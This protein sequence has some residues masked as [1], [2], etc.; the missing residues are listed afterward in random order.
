MEAQRLA[1]EAGDED[2]LLRT[3]LAALWWA[4]TRHYVTG[5]EDAMTWE[6]AEEGYRVTLAAAAHFEQRQDWGSFSETLDLHPEFAA[7]LGRAD[8]V[9]ESFRRR[10]GAPA[11]PSVEWSNALGMLTWAHRDLGQYDRAID[12]VREAL[13]RVRPGDPRVYLGEPVARAVDA[14]Y[15]TATRD[16]IEPTGAV[17]AGSCRARPGSMLVRAALAVVCR[18]RLMRLYEAENVAILHTNG[19]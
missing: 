5:E 14:A 6:E 18:V 1:Q 3:R 4:A 8:E 17:G 9:I 19:P 7:R 15:L 2:E 11:L 10:L 16:V 12:V 13:A